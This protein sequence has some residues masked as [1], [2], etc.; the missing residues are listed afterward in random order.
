MRRQDDGRLEAELET[1]GRR[2]VNEMH[3]FDT[4]AR[5]EKAL[6]GAGEAHGPG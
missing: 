2:E 4:D 6:C 1:F 3:L 5:E